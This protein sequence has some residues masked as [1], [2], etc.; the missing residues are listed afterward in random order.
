MSADVDLPSVVTGGGPQVLTELAGRTLGYATAVVIVVENDVE[1]V[2]ARFG[3]PSDGV[4]GRVADASRAV[5]RTGRP[6]EGPDLLSVPIRSGAGVSGALTLAGRLAAPRPDALELL[7]AFAQVLTDLLALLARVPGRLEPDVRTAVIADALAAGEFVAWYQ[8]IV[9]LST[10]QLVGF[11]ALARWEQASGELAMPSAFIDVAEQSDLI[12][13]LDLAI[14]ARACRDVARWHEARPDLRIGLNLSA[15][16]LDDPGCDTRL[17]GV[18]LAAGL[19]P[20]NVDVELTET[21]RPSDAAQGAETLTRLHS[22]GYSIWFDDFGT[23]W[24]ELQDLVSLPVDG[25]KI[26][27]FFAE[28]LGTRADAV[29]RAMTTAAREMG[30]S[31]TIEGISRP[32]HRERAIALG[33]DLAQG[34][35]WSPAVPAATIDRVFAGAAELPGVVIAPAG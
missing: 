17:H 35:L 1:H 14:A 4:A 26:D 24:S 10:G 31:T 11:E 5:A 21:A 2:L 16:H 25:L 20:R 30:I 27:R 22:Q 32:E 3:P 18:V 8:P 13:D 7:S 15:R 28:A 12:V 23:G 33:C 6:T 9:H 19:A 29:V 34:F